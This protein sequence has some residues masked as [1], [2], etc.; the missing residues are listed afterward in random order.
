MNLVDTAS[1]FLIYY[2]FKMYTVLSPAI[3]ICDTVKDYMIQT[4]NM[5]LFFRQVSWV[6]HILT[7]PELKPCTNGPNFQAYY[8]LLEIHTTFKW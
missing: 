3:F 7:I 4:A 8:S 5:Y 6:Y 1:L 2:V